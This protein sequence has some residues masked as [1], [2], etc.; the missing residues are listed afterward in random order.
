MSAD[1]NTSDAAVVLN[2]IA[3][4][5]HGLRRVLF[6]F[7]DKVD[8]HDS[9]SAQAVQSMLGYRLVDASDQSARKRYEGPFAPDIEFQDRVFPPYLK[10]LS[11]RD[12]IRSIWRDL[13]GLVESPEIRARLHD[14]LWVTE[15]DHRDARGAIENY[16]TAAAQ[17]NGDES[18]VKRR[19]DAV[20][21]LVRAY[22]LSREIS[23]PD[24]GQRVSVR[25]TEV[26]SSELKRQDSHSPGVWMRLLGL[27]ASMDA[28]E[29]PAG[30]TAHLARGHE[31][32]AHPH[33][34]QAVFQM[35]ERFAR[36]DPG[37]VDRIQQAEV[38]MLI[39]HALQEARGLS[40][41]YWLTKALKRARGRR[42]A[43]DTEQ[44]IVTELQ[45]IDPD[46][47]DWHT[48]TAQEEIP[49]EQVEAVVESIAGT[50]H[51]DEALTRFAIVNGVPVGER[52]DV[53]RSVDDMAQHSFFMRLFNPSVSGEHGLAIR[54]P[55]S[56]E[57]QHDID[58]LGEEA[59]RIRWDA[60]FRA[61]ALDDIGHR[62]THD[63]TVLTDFFKS[64]F[65]DHDEAD[66]FA[67]AFE[68]YWAGRPEE[69]ILV[70][71][72]KIEAVFRK[73]LEATG[74]VIYDPPQGCPPRRRKNSGYGAS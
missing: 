54:R 3:R 48:I 18:S 2:G 62:H 36:G 7:N 47:Y 19:L 21:G 61:L 1:L 66:A 68:H 20:D 30:I 57:E 74:G 4:D 14:L 59:D 6:A 5:E 46:S 25:A 9:P 45:R 52:E 42:W 16:L 64:D 26:L 37:A 40:R 50:D 55:R 63:V 71:M 31:L 69:A 38:E 8:A 72:P 11:D 60:V 39:A 56:P 53:E 43:Q 65:V 12:D 51:L 58:I 27:L 22:E 17:A 32:A 13:S 67:R 34:R 73:L 33:E 23:D 24:L 10:D 49:A 35:E 29:L 15:R 41:E 44:R 28:E 70:A